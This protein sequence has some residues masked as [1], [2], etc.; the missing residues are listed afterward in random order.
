MSDSQPRI[1][2]GFVSAG[3]ST[4]R[5]LCGVVHTVATET[6]TKALRATGD[7]ERLAGSAVTDT[8]ISPV[9]NTA[10]DKT[11]AST[12]RVAAT[13]TSVDV[14]GAAQVCPVGALEY[15]AGKDVDGVRH[16]HSVDPP[17][18]DPNM[19]GYE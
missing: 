13:V 19:Q 2:T 1:S 16:P 5:G 7:A 17:T 12:V 9:D 14:I 4:G 8:A 11:P 18:T 10:V 3:W 15:V 6:A